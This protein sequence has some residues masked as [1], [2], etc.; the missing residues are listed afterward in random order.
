MHTIY[1]Y[2]LII[3]VLIVF[4]RYLPAQT[5]SFHTNNESLN[6]C[7]GDT[8][9][10]SNTSENF[11]YVFWDFGDGFDTYTNNPKHI[12]NEAGLYTIQLTAYS[13]QG[14]EDTAQT[15]IEVHA[16]PEVSLIPPD[17]SIYTSAPNYS[18]R[19][20]GNFDSALWSDG[21]EQNSITVSQSG[22]Y[23]LK[24]FSN[25]TGCSYSDEFWIFFSSS[26]PAESG[27]SVQNNVITPNNDGIND[28]L[29]I[30][31]LEELP[32]CEIYIYN[33][34]GRLLYENK[35]YKNDWKGQSN[36]GIQLPT[37]TYYYLIK[38]AGMPYKTGF[39]DIVK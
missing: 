6:Y 11:D 20:E 26:G 25:E 15:T 33:Q 2:I 17:D 21:S 31:R 39:V 8:V 14:T 34:S 9:I 12:Y 36:N 27:I 38:A 22:H 1:N 16:L 5:A 13:S 4:A 23:S 37:G 10:F 28:V 30:N 3:S 24:V 35:A 29:Y 7:S 32:S 19:A 18:V